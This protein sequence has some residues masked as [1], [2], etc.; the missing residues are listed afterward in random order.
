MRKE[1]FIS[2]HYEAD[3]QEKPHLEA[4]QGISYRRE[5][6]GSPRRLPGNGGFAAPTSAYHSGLAVFANAC[7]LQATSER[8][9]RRLHTQAKADE[10]RDKCFPRRTKDYEEAVRIEGNIVCTP[11]EK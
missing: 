9:V 11:V 4:G 6:R 3:M 7:T 5:E 8:P 10:K 2:V 1:L